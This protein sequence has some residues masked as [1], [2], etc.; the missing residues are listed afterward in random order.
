MA[1]E[2][3][4]VGGAPERRTA[5]NRRALGPSHAV[6]SLNQG[7]NRPVCP[8]VQRSPERAPPKALRASVP[9][10]T[11]GPH[12]RAACKSR[13]LVLRAAC[14]ACLC[15]PSL[16]SANESSPFRIKLPS[17]AVVR[18]AVMA[19]P[20]ALDGLN[21]AVKA[22]IRRILAECGAGMKALVL[23]A[24]TVRSDEA[25]PRPGCDLPVR[26]LRGRTQGSRRLRGCAGA[27]LIS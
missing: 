17:A 15:C 6:S 26:C 16:L 1:S 13:A 23:D 9:A 11:K 5:N 2:P 20:S 3:R 21:G 7:R 22:Y 19:T 8:Y 10:A 27:C 18:T 4:N 14:V 24:T 12:R 25:Q